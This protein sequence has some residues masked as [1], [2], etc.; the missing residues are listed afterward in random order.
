MGLTHVCKKNNQHFFETP[1]KMVKSFG[2]LFLDGILGLWNVVS[3]FIGAT[4]PET[5]SSS[6]LKIDASEDCLV[7]I[8]DQTTFFS[9]AKM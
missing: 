2:R 1:L 7:S 3:G 6:H 5:N 4:L 8:L 9:G